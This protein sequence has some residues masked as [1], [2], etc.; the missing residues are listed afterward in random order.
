MLNKRPSVCGL[1][2]LPAELRK[3]WGVTRFQSSKPRWT[4]LEG[5]WSEAKHVHPLSPEPGTREVGPEQTEVRSLF[6]TRGESDSWIKA[7]VGGG[8]GRLYFFIWGWALSV[9]VCCVGEAGQGS[10]GAL[11][12]SLGKFKKIRECAWHLEM[13]QGSSSSPLRPS[14]AL[15]W[16]RSQTV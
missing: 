9:L 8:G 1:L 16:R 2:G 13:P 14:V 12:S 10:V 15:D 5:G 3:S 6:W 11:P 7:E 4:A